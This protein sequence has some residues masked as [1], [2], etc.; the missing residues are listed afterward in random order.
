MVRTPPSH[1]LSSVSQIV[2]FYSHSVDIFCVC[3]NIALPTTSL[4]DALLNDAIVSN[5]PLN[6]ATAVTMLL[7]DAIAVTVQ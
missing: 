5:M 6:N 1:T 3:S 2:G 4:S 7:D